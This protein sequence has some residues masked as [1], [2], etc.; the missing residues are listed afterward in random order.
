M[1]QLIK[2]SNYTQHIINSLIQRYNLTSCENED[3][4]W[5]AKKDDIPVFI[6]I[7][8]CNLPDLD[9]EL[10]DYFFASSINYDFYILVY[11]F[12]KAVNIE[13][14]T[15]LLKIDKDVWQTYFN[16]DLNEKME[17]FLEKIKTKP[18]YDKE[19][20]D[21]INYFKKCWRD[22]TPYTIKLHF[23]RGQKIKKCYMLN[24]YRTNQIVAAVTMKDFGEWARSKEKKI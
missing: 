16:I 3:T 9:I 7:Q 8:K 23:K 19:W 15:V 21:G 10:F 5:H 22:S 12:D 2:S 20:H 24:N 17:S 11:F 6:K 14:E 13:K 18:T 1:N 4:V